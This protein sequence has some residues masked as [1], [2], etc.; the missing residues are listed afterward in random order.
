MYLSHSALDHN[1]SSALPG[2]FTRTITTALKEKIIKTY[3]FE[4]KLT[5]YLSV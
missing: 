1:D 4:D 2:H 3:V 5:K